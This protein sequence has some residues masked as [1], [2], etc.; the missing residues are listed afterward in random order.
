[1]TAPPTTPHPLPTPPVGDTYLFHDGALGDSILLWPLVRALRRAPALA[2]HPAPPNPHRQ[3]IRLAF[4]PDLARLAQRV[5]AIEAQNS[6]PPSPPDAPVVAAPLSLDQHQR[7]WGSLGDE[8]GAIDPHAALV[9]TCTSREPDQL[10]APERA[11][12]R[13]LAR[14]FPNA[15]LLLAGPPGG[16]SRAQLALEL[17]A[18]TRGSVAARLAPPADPPLLALH[19]GAGGEHKRWPLPHWLL[20]ADHLS[21][22][23]P[24]FPQ[25][26]PVTDHHPPRVQLLAG[27]VELE[28]LSS[29]E[30]AA[31]H[32]AGG[33]APDTLDDLL[34]ALAPATLYVGADTGPTHLAAQLGL[35]TIAL[36]GPTDPRVWSPVGPR[37]RTLLAPDRVMTRLT[38]SAVLAAAHQTLAAPLAPAPTRGT[39]PDALSSP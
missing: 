31:F 32:A 19:I 7:L 4:R 8:P 29:T 37:V 16:R 24:P 10:A 34:G 20:L 39:R 25:R 28:R 13:R 12:T 35:P 30:L 36:F 21:R 5:F 2:P 27:H 14:A 17:H 22:E 23:R 18:P 38:V 9:I 3:S 26:S 6:A 11:W 1:M 15:L 33:I